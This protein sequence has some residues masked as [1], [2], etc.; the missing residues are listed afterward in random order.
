MRA[1]GAGEG[2]ESLVA[3]GPSTARLLLG[4]VACGGVVAAVLTG[5]SPACRVAAPVGLTGEG[6]W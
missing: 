2:A 1:G 4:V 6:G 3:R 5:F